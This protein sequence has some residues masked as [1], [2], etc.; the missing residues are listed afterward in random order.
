MNLYSPTQNAIVFH[1]LSSKPKTDKYKA[2][3]LQS[4]LSSLTTTITDF[5]SRQVSLQHL[6]GA[7]LKRVLTIFFKWGYDAIENF[8]L[9]LMHPVHFFLSVIYSDHIRYNGWK[10][11]TTIFLKLLTCAALRR[12]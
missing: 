7:F 10:S 6:A 4:T 8:K 9:Y 5:A 1:I 2:S 12:I 11:V 3:K